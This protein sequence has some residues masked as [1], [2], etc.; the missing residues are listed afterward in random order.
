[1]VNVT[2]K[3]FRTKDKYNNQRKKKYCGQKESERYEE[4][5]L[6]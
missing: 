2:A 4:P 6:K 3:R 1:M 5:L